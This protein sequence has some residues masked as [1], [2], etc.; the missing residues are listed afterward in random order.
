[1]SMLI[2][3]HPSYPQRLSPDDDNYSENCPYYEDPVLNKFAGDWA[4]Y[5]TI[6]YSDLKR[7]LVWKDGIL[8]TL[9]AAGIKFHNY[10]P[11]TPIRT[12][13][14]GRGL[15]GRFG[16]NHA[17]D[18][19]VTRFNF[20]TLDFEFVA[21]LRNDCGKFC[22]PGG[23]VDPGESVSLTLRREF[24][25]EVASEC[26]DEIL[27]RIFSNGTTLYTGPTYGDPRTTDNA[28]IET[29]VVHY[30]LDF[31]FANKIKLTPQLSENRAVRW[32]SCDSPDLYGDHAKFV[33][34]AKRN[35][36][37]IVLKKCTFNLLQWVLIPS[38]LIYGVNL[39]FK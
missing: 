13:I 12:G 2:A 23:M 33:K 19:I 6:S 17:A 30:H 14:Q 9:E 11:V 39:M 25:E 21:A 7:R 10:K 29:C 37:V 38:I 5:T 31:Y 34:M 15:L 8:V 32:I 16:P 24:K 18:P 22:I 3:T 26:S 28:W 1:M 35:A 20:M 4:D 27:D 36:Q